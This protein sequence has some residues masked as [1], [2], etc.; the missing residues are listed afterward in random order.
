MSMHANAIALVN[1]TWRYVSAL[2]E[3]V[4]YRETEPTVTAFTQ[5]GYHRNGLAP[6]DVRRFADDYQDRVIVPTL[7]PKLVYVVDEAHEVQR[8]WE[9]A[10]NYTM[11]EIHPGRYEVGYT[12]LGYRDWTPDMQ[13]DQQDAYYAKIE[14]K[15]TRLYSYWV[16]R[17]F[18]ASSAG[19]EEHG[20]ETT[21]TIHPYHYSAR[22][23]QPGNAHGRYELV[24][25][26]Q[27]EISP[28]ERLAQLE[29]L[30]AGLQDDDRMVPGRERELAILRELSA[31]GQI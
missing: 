2:E 28:I 13:G 6:A 26:I 15:A 11:Y 16:N 9:T 22:A 24:E 7:K 1:G 8:T 10:S 17:L 20:D 23:D 5:D 21:Y 3:R 12:T 31:T 30:A 25:D 19:R 14:L 27:G 4:E 29:T 18:Q